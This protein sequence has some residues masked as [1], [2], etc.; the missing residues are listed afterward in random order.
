[1]DTLDGRIAVKIP[2][3]VQTG[4][5][6]RIAGKG[7]PHRS[8]SPGDLYIKVRLVNPAHLTIEQKALY[9]KLKETVK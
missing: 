1:V 2:A 4:S 5:K 7:Y 6:I 3:G 8:G 9:E